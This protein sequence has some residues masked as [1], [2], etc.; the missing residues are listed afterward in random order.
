MWTFEARKEKQA[1]ERKKGIGRR[2]KG[3]LKM[4]IEGAN[5][6]GYGAANNQQKGLQTIN[7]WGCKQTTNGAANSE[8]NG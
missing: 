8:E 1:K 4:K 6:S 2:R 7:K 5:N 3:K